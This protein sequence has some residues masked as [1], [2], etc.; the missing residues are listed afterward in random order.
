[1][2]FYSKQYL[3]SDPGENSVEENWHKIS[4]TI[5]E[6]MDKYIPH[7]QSKP[8]KRLMNK[9]DRSHKKARRADK[10]KDL[11]VYKRL[12]NATVKRVGEAHNRYLAEVMGSINP[13]PT[14]N[15]SIVNGAKRAWSYLKFLRTE[16]TGTPTLVCSWYQETAWQCRVLTNTICWRPFYFT[17][18]LV[19][20]RTMGLTL[21]NE[22]CP[23]QVFYTVSNP[24]ETTVTIR[25]WVIPI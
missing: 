11:I 17:A 19:K 4:K 20:S 6:A 14:S 21:A 3:A 23:Q 7:K 8:V 13:A 16:S 10:P 2:S 18:G 5:H 9:R 25:I 15:S 22:F 12:R 1:M 24:Q